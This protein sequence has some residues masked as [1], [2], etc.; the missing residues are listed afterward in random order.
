MDLK[1]SEMLAA[2]DIMIVATV[3]KAKRGVPVFSKYVNKKYMTP[4]Y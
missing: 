4:L 1:L 2:S 3:N